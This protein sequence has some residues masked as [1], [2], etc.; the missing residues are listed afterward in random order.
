MHLINWRSVRGSL[1][2]YNAEINFPLGQKIQISD[3]YLI[4]IKYSIPVLSMIEFALSCSYFK[5]VVRG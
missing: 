5:G 1:Y 4:I 2:F 3:E